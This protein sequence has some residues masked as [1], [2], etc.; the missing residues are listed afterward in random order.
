M[1]GGVGQIGCCAYTHFVAQIVE[2]SSV[3]SRLGKEQ[4]EKKSTGQTNF[5]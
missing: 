1:Y 2:Y 3:T 5:G 4:K